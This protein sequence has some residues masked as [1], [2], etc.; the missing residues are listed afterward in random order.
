MPV[1]STEE[2]RTTCSNRPPRRTLRQRS[3]SSASSVASACSGFGEGVSSRRPPRPGRESTGP[4]GDFVSLAERLVPQ[5]LDGSIGR[6]MVD[7]SLPGFGAP[8]EE[9]NGSHCDREGTRLLDS[10]GRA[11]RARREDARLCSDGLPARPQGHR[12][13]VGMNFLR[14]FNFEVRPEECLIHL[15]LIEPWVPA[16]QTR[17][18]VAPIAASLNSTSAFRCAYAP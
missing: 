17:W 13:L 3:G 5:Q 10:R 9:I 14:H 1:Q 16:R 4:G 2:R 6:R 11:H 8:A 7:A 18:N 15:E 12:R